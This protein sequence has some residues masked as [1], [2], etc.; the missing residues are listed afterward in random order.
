MNSRRKQTA[1]MIRFFLLGGIHPD[2]EN[3]K[4]VLKRVQSL[5]LKG[6][7]L[8]PEYQH[9]DFDDIRYLR[10]IDYA[11]GLGLITVVHAGFDVSF[12]GSRHS[13]TE[14]ILNV[15]EKVNPQRLVLAHMG[16]YNMW[17]DVKKYIAGADVYLDTA[18]SFGK[19]QMAGLLDE[20]SFIDL[21]R[22]HG[23]KRILFATDSPWGEQK[24]MAEFVQNCALTEQ[25]KE[26]ILYKNASRLLHPS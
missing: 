11:E 1:A 4:D 5:G 12:P 9:T 15:L 2:T 19:K 25:E 8:H 10:I 24:E 3:Y 18:F 22:T 7:K 26:D 14:K 21:A 13:H 6:I 16:G 20:R 23:I 17:E